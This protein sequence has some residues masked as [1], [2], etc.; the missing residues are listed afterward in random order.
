MISVQNGGAVKSMKTD[1]SGKN[2]ACLTN[3]MRRNEDVAAAAVRN[4]S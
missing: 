4:M 1:S 3:E 2:Y